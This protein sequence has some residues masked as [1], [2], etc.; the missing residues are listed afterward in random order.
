M[1][2]DF[3]NIS[4][5]KKSEINEIY[6]H[7]ERLFSSKQAMR[8]L[9]YVQEFRIKSLFFPRGDIYGLVHAGR[10]PEREICGEKKT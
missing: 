5:I 2:K 9:L 6:L 7:E 1:N 4:G 3:N 10:Q 8:H